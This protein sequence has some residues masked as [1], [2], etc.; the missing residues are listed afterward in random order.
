MKRI[1]LGGVLVKNSPYGLCPKLTGP[2]RYRGT[3]RIESC[4]VMV[5]SSWVAPRADAP[6]PN[7]DEGRFFVTQKQEE[8][9][10]NNES[11]LQL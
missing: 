1:Q 11:C 9:L 10:R 5:R 8:R 4:Y 6:R 3:K 7:S 2:A